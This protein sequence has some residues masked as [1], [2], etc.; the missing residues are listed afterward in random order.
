MQRPF[1]EQRE[2]LD[3]WDLEIGYGVQDLYSK[4]LLPK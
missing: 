4:A 2:E 3:K 1:P